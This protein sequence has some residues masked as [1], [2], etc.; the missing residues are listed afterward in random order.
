MVK[1]V[2][3]KYTETFDNIANSLISYLA[4][5]ID[6]YDALLKVE[7]IIEAFEKRVAIDPLSCPV[8]HPLLELG[9]TS[10]REYNYNGF[11]LLYRVFEN[12]NE[13]TIQGDA[14]LSHRQDIQ[15]ALIEYC[16][17]YR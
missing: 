3:I 14:I 12:E 9:V 5:Y 17:I 15:Q 2:E 1:S 7:S 13:I 10:F 16:L 11:R 4:S 6:E 8:S